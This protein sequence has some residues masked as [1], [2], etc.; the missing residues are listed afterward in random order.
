MS[1]Y[2]NHQTAIGIV[3]IV[4]S[5]GLISHGLF[6]IIN[7]YALSKLKDGRVMT[8]TIRNFHRIAIFLKAIRLITFF[9]FLVPVVLAIGFLQGVCFGL[10]EFLKIFIQSISEMAILILENFYSICGYRRLS[11]DRIR[12]LQGKQIKW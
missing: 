2:S 11:D 5:I 10:I 6:L 7:K 4:F 8:G 3:S 12:T 1:F 9:P